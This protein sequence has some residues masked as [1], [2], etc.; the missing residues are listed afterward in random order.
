MTER[1]RRAVSAVLLCA[2]IMVL[3]W[4][5]TAWGA[6]KTI[7]RG[8]WQYDALDKLAQA[9]L[10]DGYPKAPLPT[11]RLSRF[12]AAALALRAVQGLGKAYQQ[13]GRAFM[14]AA[15]PDESVPEGPVDEPEAAAPAEETPEP[16]LPEGL[17]AENLERVRKLIDEFNSELVTMEGRIDYIQ[18]ILSDT[19]DRLTKVEA[20]QKKHAITGYMQLRYR[21]DNAKEG[22][23]EFQVRRVRVNVL[24]PV[25]PKTSYRVEMQF[26]SKETGK[27]PGSKAQLRTAFIDYKLGPVSRFRMGQAVLPWGY[28]LEES[29]P[30]L[31]TGE[32]SLWMDRLFPDQRDIGA[33][34]NYRRKPTSPM[35]D[36]GIV[37]GTNI[38][39]VDNNNKS[40]LLARVDFPLKSGSVALSGYTGTNAEGTART[41]QDREGISARYHW[42]DTQ[43]LGEF[44]TGNDK[45]KDMRGY[46]W[47]LGHPLTSA[48]PN[49][50]FVKYDQYDENR[51]KADDLFKRWSLGYWYDLDKA[52]RLTLVWELRDAG[53][54]FSEL[55]KWNGNAAYAQLQVKF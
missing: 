2:L 32:R 22:R 16:A 18:S 40:N 34:L 37:N 53:P 55:T 19:Q 39:A 13:Q 17:T 9:G 30:N 14:L 50:L 52:T 7:E 36:F 45:G 27:G 3:A 49:L 42:G 23:R 21:D 41:R 44:V 26:D 38:N 11:D 43:F 46:Y 1:P 4:G 6:T 47:Q 28:E 20:D 15:A 31:W 5:A 54:K 24:G 8:D 12:E 25:S 10:L 33:F 51:S 35:F 48:S 29:V